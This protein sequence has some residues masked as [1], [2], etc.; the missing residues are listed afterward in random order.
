VAAA[1]GVAIAFVALDSATYVQ[2]NSTCGFFGPATGTVSGHV[3]DLYVLW[4]VGIALL[5]LQALR[6][7]WPRPEPPSSGGGRPGW[8]QLPPAEG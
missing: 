1:L 4:G 6:L 7:L 2:Q 3:G 8:L 5:L